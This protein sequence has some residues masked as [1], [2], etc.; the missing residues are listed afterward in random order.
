MVALGRQTAGDR[1]GTDRDQ[2]LAVL[3]EFAQHMH[4]FRVADA[5]FDN[6]DVAR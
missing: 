3:S 4:V 2:Y 5:A 6:A 1:A